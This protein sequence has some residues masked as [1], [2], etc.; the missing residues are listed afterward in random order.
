MKIKEMESCSGIDRATIRYYEKEGLLDPSRTD[1]GYREY[2]ET[3]LDQLMKIKLL[4]SLHISLVDIRS[5][6]H[7]KTNLRDI[8]SAQIKELDK[9]EDD[10]GLARNI[11]SSIYKNEINYTRLNFMKYLH[12]IDHS[13]N[14]DGSR[15]FKFTEELPMFYDPFRRFFARSFDFT[16]YLFIWII[17]QIFV[18]NISIL[19]RTGWQYTTDL[20]VAML[21]MILIEPVLLHRTKTTAGKSILGLSIENKDGEHL[22]YKEAFDR[23]L[24]VAIKGWV[25]HSL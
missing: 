16:L 19:S 25:W 20:I 24:E 15:Y 12:E 9:E 6:I 2:S 5:L 3:D 21:I 11:C 7:G 4:R 23:T 1:N 10:I 17:S 13:L 22:S 8:I 18:M 14:E